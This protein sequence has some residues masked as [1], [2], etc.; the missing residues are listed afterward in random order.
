MVTPMKKRSTRNRALLFLVSFAIAVHAP[1]HAQAT[2]SISQQPLLSLPERLSDAAFWKLVTDIS[3]PGGYFRMADNFVSNEPN[4]GTIAGK[5]TANGPTGGVYLGVGP[6]QNFT[7]IAAVRPRMAFI[8]DIRRQAMMH[9]L[10]YKAIFE[11]SRDRAD[12][13]SLLF[14]KP[15]PEGIAANTPI[16]RIW[17]AFDSVATDTALA[18]RS[19]VRLRD[20]LTKTHGFN[21]TPDELLSLNHVYNSFV[22]FG[23]RIQTGGPAATM[24]VS[25]QRWADTSS[26]AR[27]RAL[28][29]TSLATL[30]MRLTATAQPSAGRSSASTLRTM[31]GVVNFVTLTSVTDTAGQLNSFLGSDESFQFLKDLHS[32][33]LFVPNSGN[34]GGPKAIRAV[35][36]YV[37]SHGAAISAFYVSNVET[38]LFQDGIAGIFYDNVATLPINEKSVFIRPSGPASALCPIATMLRAVAAGAVT[39]FSSA[40]RCA[41]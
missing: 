10:L 34:F 27:Q 38:Y 12:F 2:S 29:D 6:E 25:Y 20:H 37:R 24:F 17:V 23:P 1:L 40:S 41:Q 33:N 14:A 19:L 16:P 21:L 11:L 36:E 18:S 32:K 39:T 30:A 13:I 3:E 22:S 28:M 7:Y 9:H 5:I 4:I 15:R 26:A 8:V 31:G 35:G